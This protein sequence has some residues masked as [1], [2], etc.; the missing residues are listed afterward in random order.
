MRLFDALSSKLTCRT[1]KANTRLFPYTWGEPTLICPIY[2]LDGTRIMVTPILDGALRRLRYSTH[3]RT[4]WV[5]AMCINQMDNRENGVQIP[6]MVRVFRG[7]RRVLAWL[8]PGGRDS[9]EE[10]CMRLLERLS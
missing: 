6:L 2:L 8:G 3:K 1:S 5:D 4:L 10:G 9:E 7:A